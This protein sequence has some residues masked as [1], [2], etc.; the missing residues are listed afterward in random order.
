MRGSGCRSLDVR[1]VPLGGLHDARYT[2]VELELEPGDLIACFSDGVEECASPGGK[3]LGEGWLADYLTDASR[4]P[5]QSIA[6]RLLELSSDFCGGS[7]VLDD[8]TVII[9]KAT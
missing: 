9:L 2:E 3:P 8:R 4:Q 5:A 6:N 7:A 1:G